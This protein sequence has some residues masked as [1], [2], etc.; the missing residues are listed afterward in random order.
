MLYFLEHFIA[1]LINYYSQTA[2][3]MLF[4]NSNAD[5]A[6]KF[7]GW[8]GGSVWIDDNSCNHAGIAG[9]AASVGK[10]G[11]YDI[12]AQTGTTSIG[13]GSWYVR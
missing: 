1:R 8:N 9:T 4:E 10:A 3:L 5:Y 7:A 6:C 13:K 11:C 2:L 12:G